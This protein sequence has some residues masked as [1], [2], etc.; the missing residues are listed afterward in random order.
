MDATYPPPVPN[1]P[2]E[3]K[4]RTCTGQ[5]ARNLA[6]LDSLAS[7]R[8]CKAAA[9]HLLGGGGRSDERL[10]ELFP[11][12]VALLTPPAGCELHQQHCAELAASFFQSLCDQVGLLLCSRPA[13]IRRFALCSLNL[14]TPHYRGE[15][16]VAKS[17]VSLNDNRSVSD[18]LRCSDRSCSCIPVSSLPWLPLFVK[19]P[20]L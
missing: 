3:G 16:E 17:P 20:S 1:S 10:T 4:E 9:L 13:V 8:A 19:R 7:H 15:S 2:A 5:T 18:P 14:H 11:C 6:L 12:L